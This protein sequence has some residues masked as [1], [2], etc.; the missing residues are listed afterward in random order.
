MP[1]PSRAELYK[2]EIGGTQVAERGNGSGSPCNVEYIAQ[3]NDALRAD[4]EAD[5][6]ALGAQLARRGLDIDAVAAKVAAFGVAIPSW[7]VGTGGTRFA[8]FP[9]V[10]EPR[11]VYEKL[12]DCAVTVSYTHLTLPTKRIV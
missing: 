7:G 10:G 2:L 8:R 3:R 12:E 5:Y 6:A 11:N 4:A 1:R 9:G